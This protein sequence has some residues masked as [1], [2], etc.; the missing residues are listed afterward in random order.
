VLNSA[1]A[2]RLAFGICLIFLVAGAFARAGALRSMRWTKIPSVTV[3][4]KAG[5]SRL[6]A[7]RESILFW[8]RTFAGL[9]TPFR[10]GDPV[11]VTGTIPDDDIQSLGDQ[12]LHQTVSSTMP[13]SL[14]RVPGDLLII[15]SDAQFISYTAFRGDRVIVAI[16]NGGIP[17]LALPNVLRNVIAHELGHAVGLEHN[18]DPA[19]LMCG[20]PAACRPD[21]FEEPS[22]RFFP[23]SNAE[24]ER[25]LTLY[26]RNEGI[27]PN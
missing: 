4:S 18:Q 8:N 17:P 21:A 26:P 22:P 6:E 19:L 5:D 1:E 10:L 27:S 2:K 25:L 13:G 12:V 3:V 7:V 15:L 20:R 14:E 11:F 23:L 24:R 9:G 16:K